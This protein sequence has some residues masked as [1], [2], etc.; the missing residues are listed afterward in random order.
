MTYEK[1]KEEGNLTVFGGKLMFGKFGVPLENLRPQIAQASRLI[2]PSRWSFC[3]QQPHGWRYEHRS[4][5]Q[6]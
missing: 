6:P 2:S 1:Y 3:Q 5:V 4:Y